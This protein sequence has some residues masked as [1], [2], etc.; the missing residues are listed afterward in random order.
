MT[1]LQMPSKM[2]TCRRW[3]VRRDTRLGGRVVCTVIDT[4][5]STVAVADCE[6]ADTRCPVDAADRTDAAQHRHL[7]TLT[8]TQT[9]R[10]YIASGNVYFV[11]SVILML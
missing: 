4:T 6:A 7:V 9:P 8:A 11:K 2:K 10:L 3:A 1:T 5:V